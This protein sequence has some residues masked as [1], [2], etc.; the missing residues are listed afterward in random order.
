MKYPININGKTVKQVTKLNLSG[1]NLKEIPENVFEYTNL[2]KLVLSNNQIK[3]IPKDILKLKK[4][5]VLDMANNQISMLHS[6][7]FNLPKLRTLNIYG[8]MIKKLPKQIYDSKIRTLIAGKN[9]IEEFD[10]H[11][12]AEFIKVDLSNNK[13]NEIT[14]DYDS[15]RLKELRIK[16]NPLKVVNVADNIRRQLEYCDVELLNSKND[17]HT[18]FVTK[19]EMIMEGM[20]VVQ[21]HSVFI[22]YSHAD[23]QWLEKVLKSLKPLQRYYKNLEAWSDQQI[24]A[25]DVWKDEINKALKKATIAILLVSPDFL[26]SDFIAN[27]ELQPLLDKAQEDGT[28]IMPIVI[29]PCASFLL[30]ERGILKYQAVNDPKNPLSGM[31]E[32]DQDWTFAN[33]VETIKK[34]IDKL[35]EEKRLQ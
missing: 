26:A 16:S 15:F 35:A 33:M 29:R 5:K 11:A 19:K 4:L 9:Q 31:N 7:V 18:D 24:M 22:S 1:L 20:E 21:K 34:I 6:A 8:N 2:T 32:V 23:K 13:L 27:E 3:A 12:A 10:F 30:E 25:S 17:T 14:I 28:K